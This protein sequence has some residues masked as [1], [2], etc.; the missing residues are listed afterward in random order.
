M[1][2]HLDYL[3]LFNY[4]AAAFYAVVGAVVI[5]VSLA[6]VWAFVGPVPA[7]EQGALFG[8]LA[9]GV[10]SCWAFAVFAWAMGSRVSEGRWRGVQTVWAAMSVANNPPLGTAYGLYALWVCWVNPETR[11]A[12]ERAG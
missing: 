4:M 6:L 9:L 7:E 3:G 8:A 1:S 10:V 12:F 2:N 5:P 11:A